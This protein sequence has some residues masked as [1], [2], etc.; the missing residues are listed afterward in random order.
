[1][2]ESA[3]ARVWASSA[4]PCHSI[5]FPWTA[6]T[7]GKRPLHRTCSRQPLW[8]V[9]WAC[10]WDQTRD[11]DRKRSPQVAEGLQWSR[12]IHSLQSSS[13]ASEDG[14][15]GSQTFGDR[16]IS[17]IVIKA[18]NNLRGQLSHAFRQ[19]PCSVWRNLCQAVSGASADGTSKTSILRKISLN[20]WLT[21]F[22]VEIVR[23]IELAICKID[24]GKSFHIVFGLSNVIFGQEM[25]ELGR[26][27]IVHLH[28]LQTLN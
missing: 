4:S 3:H 9:C 21:S 7:S 13:S 24:R 19:L 5:S 6:Y 25:V 26:W 15:V 1:M 16:G 22:H 28:L 27:S 23:S 11:R 17:P 18:V 2:R 12:W 10:C 14:L 8:S 20:R